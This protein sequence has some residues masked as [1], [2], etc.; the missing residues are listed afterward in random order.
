MSNFIAYTGVLVPWVSK[1]VLPVLAWLVTIAEVVFGVLLII[2]YQKRIVALL[3][4]VLLLT[5]AFS[6]MFF[7]SLKAPLDYSVFTASACSFLLY[8]NSK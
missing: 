4:G 1:Q 3:S 7:S 2:G 6:M 5:F 8:K